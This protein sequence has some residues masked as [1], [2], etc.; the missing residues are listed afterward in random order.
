MQTNRP[1][2]WNEAPGAAADADKEENGQNTKSAS[3]WP[4]LDEQA[5]Y[6]LFGTIVRL[7]EPHTEA[8]R[9]A[10][11]FQLLASFG[12]ALEQVRFTLPTA[13]DITRI[14]SVALLV[15]RRAAAREPA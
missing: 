13:P 7:I 10:I 4:T 5:F 6:G 9:A 14:Y 15:D 11:L 12:N 2:S 3:V 1:K 8:D